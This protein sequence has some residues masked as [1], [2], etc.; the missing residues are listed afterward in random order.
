[1]RWRLKHLFQTD[2]ARRID[3]D[4]YLRKGISHGRIFAHQIKLFRLDRLPAVRQR[5]TAR[6]ADIPSPREV[7]PAATEPQRQKSLHLPLARPRLDHPDL[8][9]R[10]V[11]HPQHAVLEL[12]HLLLPTLRIDDHGAHLRPAT[13][14]LEI[15][16]PG[17]VR[18]LTNDRFVVVLREVRAR[19]L[20][21]LARSIHLR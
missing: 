12:Q 14:A 11:E 3:P 2:A 19:V 10:N 13:L 6:V 20:E 21:L 15:N 18:R 1:M 9:V 17:L 7:F 5:L 16:R 8:V 4:R